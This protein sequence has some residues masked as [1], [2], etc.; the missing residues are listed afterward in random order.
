MLPSSHLDQQ[1][2]LLLPTMWAG[3]DSPQAIQGR[4][5]GI[6]TEYPNYGPDARGGVSLQNLQDGQN[7]LGILHEDRKVT[8]D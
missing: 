8:E 3:L 6:S 4:S 5:T 2:I 1:D 7:D